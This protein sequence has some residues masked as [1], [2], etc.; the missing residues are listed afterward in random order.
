MMTSLY[1]D[2]QFVGGWAV[3]KHQHLCLDC[4]KQNLKL[5]SDEWDQS[6]PYCG[7]TKVSSSSPGICASWIFWV[8]LRDIIMKSSVINSG[9]APWTIIYQQTDSFIFL[10]IKEIEKNCFSTMNKIL[11]LYVYNRDHDPKPVQPAIKS[12]GDN[13]KC[14]SR[15]WGIMDH[16]FHNND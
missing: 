10:F 5:S 11:H 16:I 3:M 9:Q 8:L 7:V 12:Y 13:R 15:K 4:N 1:F 14:Q 6:L 2:I